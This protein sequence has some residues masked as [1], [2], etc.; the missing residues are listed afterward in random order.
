MNDAFMKL[1]S[2]LLLGLTAICSA[3]DPLSDGVNFLRAHMPPKDQQL[4]TPTRLETEVR[5]ALEA[6]E[7]FPWA[8]QVPW[9]IYAN[10]VLPYAVVNEPRDEWRTQFLQTFTP[11][12]ATCKTG[13]EAVLAIASQIQHI[14]N[15]K[16]ST[17]R[18]IP[19]Q[20]VRE[21]LQSGKVSCTGQSILLICALR[22]VG[23]PARMTGLLTWNHVQGNHNW[24]EAWSDGEWHMIE[25]NEKEFNTPWV[26]SAIS[27]L[28]P[29]KPENAIYATSWKNSGRN[30]FFPMI[31]EARFNPSSRAIEF[32][33]E[34]RSV[35]AVNITERYMNMAS[36][37]VSRQPEYLPGSK[38]MLDITD[39]VNGKKQRMPIKVVLKA[40]EG[41]ILA[42]GIS[43]GPADDMRKFLELQLPDKIAQGTLELHL[44]DG[45][46]QHLTVT[47]TNAPVQILRLALD[48]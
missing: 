39:K 20:G 38:L 45:R 40:E 46:V 6:R 19:H 24:V 18:R 16:Y 48:T 42:E 2:L 7:L 29:Q 9:D 47:H 30:D 41:D 5:T 28:D 3:Q 8:K 15:V 12:V 13:A 32:P 14:L 25:Y 33:P 43:P 37:W 1:F 22:S 35:P 34:S 31:W 17:E 44:P 21:S 26:M 4:M 10:D 23:I 27:M 11:I 36:D